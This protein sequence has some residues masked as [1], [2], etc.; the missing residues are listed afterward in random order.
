MCTKSKCAGVRLE[1]YL[2]T[3]TVASTATPAS[4]TSFKISRRSLIRGLFPFRGF[5]AGK[6]CTRGPTLIRARSPQNEPHLPRSDNLHS[7]SASRTSAPR[8]FSLDGKTRRAPPT[9]RHRRSCTSRPR[10]TPTQSSM[11]MSISITFA[12]TSPIVT[13]VM[14]TPAPRAARRFPNRHP[15]PPRHPRAI[16]LVRSFA[17]NRVAATKFCAS[18][19][20]RQQI[21]KRREAENIKRLTRHRC[22]SPRATTIANSCCQALASHWRAC[23]CS[24]RT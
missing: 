5:V 22:S 4:T 7:L 21:K 2:S 12:H 8:R 18:I 16:A 9:T 1:S 3:I 19:A 24:N 15:T 13:L 6:R 23:R 20:S 17:R 10:H 14:T 11:H